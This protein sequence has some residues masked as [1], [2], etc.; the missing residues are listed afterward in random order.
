LVTEEL[1]ESCSVLG[2]VSMPTVREKKAPIKD[3]MHTHK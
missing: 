2:V 1:E 3:H